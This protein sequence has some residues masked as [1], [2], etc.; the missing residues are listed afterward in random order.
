MSNRLYQRAGRGSYMV[1]VPLVFT[2]KDILKPNWRSTAGSMIENT[3][4]L[5]IDALE[6]AE[7]DIRS[8]KNLGRRARG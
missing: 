5:Y 3:V 8:K 4:R 6:Q 1:R 7:T 2:R